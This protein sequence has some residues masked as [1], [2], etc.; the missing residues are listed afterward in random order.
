MTPYDDTNVFAKILRGEIPCDKVFENE[1]ALAF[2]DLRSASSDS[3]LNYSQGA[4]SFGTRFF[5]HCNGG[6]A[7][8]FC[9]CRCRSRGRRGSRR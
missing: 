9:P 2:R 5:Q 1:S 8:G 4:V 6:G 3:H 7:F